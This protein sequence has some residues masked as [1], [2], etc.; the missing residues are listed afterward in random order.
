MEP[1]ARPARKLASQYSR[2]GWA[3]SV[4]VTVTSVKR[5]IK[6][7]PTYCLILP[8]L[9]QEHQYTRTQVLG[10]RAALYRYF[11]QRL[12]QKFCLMMSRLRWPLLFQERPPGQMV[13]R[14]RMTGGGAVVRIL[15]NLPGAP[16]PAMFTE[17]V[18]A[19]PGSARANGCWRP[20]AEENDDAHGVHEVG[21]A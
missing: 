6:L 4:Y 2:P 12:A 21:A 20:G 7:L 10:L 13:Q 19:D 15:S 9:A 16:A 17:M 5:S 11:S 8:P 14:G 1:T 3:A 18:H